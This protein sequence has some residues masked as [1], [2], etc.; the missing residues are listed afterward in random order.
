[1][2]STKVDPE[3]HDSRY[4]CPLVPDLVARNGVGKRSGP[5]MSGVVARVKVEDV[6]DMG[7]EQVVAESGT[8]VELMVDDVG[9]RSRLVLWNA[10]EMI[11]SPSGHLV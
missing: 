1:M 2:E 4:R 7:I 6:G 5:S 8:W 10:L 11:F 9:E 3:S